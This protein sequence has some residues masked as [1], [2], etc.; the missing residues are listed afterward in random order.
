LLCFVI[1]FCFAC[2]PFQFSVN[3]SVISFIITSCFTLY[4]AV[5][6]LLSSVSGFPRAAPSEDDILSVTNGNIHS[7][8]LEHDNGKPLVIPKEQRTVLGKTNWYEMCLTTVLL[9]M[10]KLMKKVQFCLLV[11]MCYLTGKLVPSLQ[12]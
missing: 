6:P 7:L 9:L 3:N 5:L 8:D 12:R 1:F 11:S 2:L 10:M 4:K